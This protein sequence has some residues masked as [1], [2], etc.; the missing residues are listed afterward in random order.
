MPRQVPLEGCE[1]PRAPTAA[2]N[3]TIQTGTIDLNIAITT[4][5]LAPSGHLSVTFEE[6]TP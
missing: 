3:Q 2:P 4:L 5:H 6:E 1:P